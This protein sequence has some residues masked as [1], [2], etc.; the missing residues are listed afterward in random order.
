MSMQTETFEQLGI[1]EFKPSPFQARTN[2]DDADLKELADSIK[3][4]GII[5]PIIGRR[6][7]GH[8]EIVAGERRWRAAKA[9][10]VAKVPVILRDL[11]DEQAAEQT[12]IENDQRKD[13]DDLD[14]AESYRRLRDLN[15]T[16]YT[17]EHLAERVGK[18]P[19]TV[20]LYLK[21]LDL[22]PEAKE[23][24]RAGKLDA[25]H[26]VLIARLGKEDQKQVLGFI[27]QQ[28][29]Y[30]QQVSVQT[31]KNYIA[32]QIK[33]DLFG[34]AFAEEH[35]KVA[36]KL[37]ELKAKGV[38]V[39]ELS[40]SYLSPKE[41]K[42]QSVIGTQNYR[43]AGKKKCDHTR[44]GAFVLGGGD[45]QLTDVCTEKKCKTHW[46]ELARQRALTTKA[47]KVK[48]E[49]PATREKRLKAEAA[50]TE[51][52]ERAERL[53]P[54]VVR[55][56][57]LATKKLDRAL[58]AW[59]IADT[60]SANAMAQHKDL[61]KEIGLKADIW[62]LTAKDV[63]GLKDPQIAQLAALARVSREID[64]AAPSVAVPRVAKAY[65]ID[66][67]KLDAELTAAATKQKAEAATKKAGTK[68]R[69]KKR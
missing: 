6:V 53:E 11:S 60:F 55:R 51:R 64:D 12:L 9:A 58:I 17:V 48:K 38:P 10:G 34:P 45:V 29:G 1:K 32:R 7:N 15:P 14:R 37:E 42:E 44:V 56:V 39:A 65:G 68:A 67:K 47:A 2:F 69:S 28:L 36:K 66:L 50:E 63:Q 61:A 59:L 25:G 46:P 13:L 57:V 62:N 23:Q 31:L 41:E 19:A 4:N 22:I 24:L 8:V 40:R 16:K 54:H 3:S 49:S 27:K 20:Y 35:P 43:E 30:G 5:E 26:G 21:L 33:V 18:K 52:R